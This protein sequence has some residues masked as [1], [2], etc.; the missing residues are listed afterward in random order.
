MN[1]TRVS[2]S[3]TFPLVSMKDLNSLVTWESFF[4][5]MSA[6]LFIEDSSPPPAVFHLFYDS[7]LKITLNKYQKEGYLS[8]DFYV[9]FT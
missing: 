1:F 7:L 6:G 2:A 8:N 4:R 9:T 3:L 5:A